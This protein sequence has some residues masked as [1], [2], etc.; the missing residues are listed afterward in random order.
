MNYNKK[1]DTAI[2]G[3]KRERI[4]AQDLI[5][6]TIVIECNKEGATLSRNTNTFLNIEVTVSCIIYRNKRTKLQDGDTY[7]TVHGK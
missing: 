4:K 7:G 6:N 1:P 5:N 3:Y 2:E